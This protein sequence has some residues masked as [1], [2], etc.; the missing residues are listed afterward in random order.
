MKKRIILHLSIVVSSLFISGTVSAQKTSDSIDGDYTL[1]TERRAVPLDVSPYSEK[2]VVLSSV[3]LEKSIRAGVDFLLT[4]Q[5]KDGSWG[6]AQKTKR[7]NIYAPLP[8]AHLAYRMGSTTLALAGMIEAKDDRP[9]VTAAIEKCE[10][11]M[12]NNL[13]HL[14]RADITSTYNVWGHAYALKAL[15]A[16]SKREGVTKEKLAEYQEMAQL[17]IDVLLV[18]QDIDGGWGYLT[19]IAA[20]RP[21]GGSMSFTT[22]TVLVAIHDAMQVFDLKFDA[23]RKTAAVVSVQRQRVADFSYVY[24]EGHKNHPRVTINR[25]GG[26]LARSQ[27]CNLA[28]KLYGDEKV[29]DQVIVSWLDRL[30][31]RNGWLDIARKRPIPHETHFS[32]SGYFYFYGHYYAARSFEEIPE[33]QRKEWKNK[34]GKI[35]ISRQ[36]G[37]G[38]FWNYPLYNYHQSYGTGYALSSLVRCR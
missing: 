38:S 17:Q 12:L 4:H 7:L 35:L 11:W 10:K 37:D 23:T 30:V 15:V 24:A 33:A 1:P 6:N 3:E 26:S 14:K 16:L 25:P 2:N 9:E 8:G 20:T 5:N 34:I 29:T 32:V 22:S 36:D 18:N 31:K 13:P 21:T 19:D 27:V 28:L